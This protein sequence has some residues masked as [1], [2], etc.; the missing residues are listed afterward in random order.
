LTNRTTLSPAHQ[1]T[2]IELFLEGK[3]V[4][5]IARDIGQDYSKVRRFADRIIKSNPG[6]AVVRATKV[7]EHRAITNATKKRVEHPKGWEPGYNTET[8]VAMLRSDR[9]LHL[10]EFEDEFSALLEEWGFDPSRFRIEDDK[11]EIR[12]WDAHYGVHK[13]PKKFWYYKARVIRKPPMVNAL[14]LDNLVSHIRTRKPLKEK[15]WTPGDRTFI[16][17]NA[18]WQLGKRD[19]RGTEYA[20]NAIKRTIPMISER[21]TALRNQGHLVDHL[22]IA[23]MG[24]IIEGCDGFYP[25]QTYGVE[26]S[27]REQVR[28]GRELQVAQ[29]MAWADDFEKVTVLTIP[30]NHGEYR[31]EQGKVFTNNGDNDDIAVTEQV[32]E[33][34]D[35]AN[36][37]SGGR[38]DHVKFLIPDN[39]MSVV[40]DIN[41]TIVGF[42]HG[43]V[44]GFRPKVGKDLSASKLWDWWY[45]QSMGRQPVADADLLLT[46][47][48]HYLSVVSQGGRTHI[49]FPPM[50]DGSE[51]FMEASGMGS[52]AATA[53]LLVGGGVQGTYQ[54]WSDLHV[55]DHGIR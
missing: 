43:H 14:D 25:D 47:H 10:D 20:V 5:E 6:E 16:V 48:Y 26:L 4:R 54:G 42:T 53:T 40:L 23:N 30:G 22:F 12:T 51:W 38:Y 37:A 55:I 45:G 15:V 18:D 39:Q 21:Y 50:E 17:G 24:D 52:Y 34:F 27:R 1:A 2:I 49:Q 7:A 41:G 28:L 35:L 11:V 9:S 46:A 44:G 3:P 29:I 36:T 19:G 32:A 31:N 13:P 33:A 8:G